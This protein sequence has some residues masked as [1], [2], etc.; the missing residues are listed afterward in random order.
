ME[1]SVIAFCRRAAKGRSPMARVPEAVGRRAGAAD[2]RCDL[3]RLGGGPGMRLRSTA[4]CGDEGQ[5]R[6][7]GD[8]VKS[9]FQ[10][11]RLPKRHR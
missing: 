11:M 10:A 9:N 7:S 2:E 8:E 5:G 3:T 1:S 6:E 4:G